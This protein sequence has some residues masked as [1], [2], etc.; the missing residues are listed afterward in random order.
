M[1]FTA[2]AEILL[3]SV[4]KAFQSLI[5]S[6]GE[7]LG[8]IFVIGLIIFSLIGSRLFALKISYGS[9][10][11]KSQEDWNIFSANK[12][13]L[14]YLKEAASSQLAHEAQ[15]GLITIQGLIGLCPLLGVLGTVTGM[16]TVFDALSIADGKDLKLLAHGISRATVPTLGGMGVAVA[17][18]IM[19]QYLV[20]TVDVKMKEARVA[21][22][23]IFDNRA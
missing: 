21:I 10:I 12:N 4:I 19:R 2:E 6:G 13:Y 20:K 1:D 3:S 14:F 8:V 18:I 17:G 23:E 9:I 5:I 7:V 11:K 16:I 15:K 22:N